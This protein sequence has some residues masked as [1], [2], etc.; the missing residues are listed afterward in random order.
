[1]QHKQTRRAS[2]VETLTNVAIGYIVAVGAQ[3][4][5]FPWFGIHIS[6]AADAAIGLLFT[7]VSIVRSYALRRMFETLRVKGV[8]Q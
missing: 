4:V 1:M 6:L 5:I 8:M 3:V 7:V 2:L